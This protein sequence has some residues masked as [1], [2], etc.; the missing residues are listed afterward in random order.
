[1]KQG[2]NVKHKT[3]NYTGVI[4]DEEVNGFI[5][6]MPD[7]LEI[8]ELY[9]FGR[10]VKI[11][12]LIDMDLWNFKIKFAR[13]YSYIGHNLSDKQI[14]DF[15]NEAHVKDLPLEHQMDMFQDYLIGNGL[16]EV[17]E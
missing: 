7:K 17:Q 6:V 10:Q 3:Q 15:L 4:V 2:T 11:K 9:P 1:M 13:T 8:R 12:E 5:T 16:C 14:Q